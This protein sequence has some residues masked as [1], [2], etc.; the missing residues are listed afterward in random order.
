MQK[1]LQNKWNKLYSS[2]PKTLEK[3]AK[4]LNNEE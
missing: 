4:I 1:T 3:M 2:A